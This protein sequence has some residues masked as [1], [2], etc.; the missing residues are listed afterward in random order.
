[1]DFLVNITPALDFIG[2]IIGWVSILLLFICGRKIVAQELSA[3][4]KKFTK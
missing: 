1:M 4:L 2:K 3:L